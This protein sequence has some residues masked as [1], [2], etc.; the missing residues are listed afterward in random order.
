MKRTRI[1]AGDLEGGGVEGRR[2][3][4]ADAAPDE[5]NEAAEA[6]VDEVV[7]EKDNPKNRSNRLVV[8]KENDGDI[9]GSYKY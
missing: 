4:K 7:R 3:E 9:F 1:I 8:I 6:R 5:K 2:P